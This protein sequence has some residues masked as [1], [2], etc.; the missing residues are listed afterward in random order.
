MHHDL[1]HRGLLS[2]LRDEGFQPRPEPAAGPVQTNPNKYTRKI[3]MRN[4]HRL[5]AAAGPL[6]NLL[7]AAFAMALLSMI[8]VLIVFIVAQGKFVQGIAGTGLKG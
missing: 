5:V 1:D 6:S 3:S 4:G 7:F 8:P 2:S